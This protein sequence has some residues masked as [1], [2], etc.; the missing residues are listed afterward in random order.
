MFLYFVPQNFVTDTLKKPTLTAITRDDLTAIGLEYLDRVEARHVSVGPGGD[1][2]WLVYRTIHA[3]PIYEPP[4]Q[5]WRLRTGKAGLYIGR[6]NGLT[7]GPS[8]L[9]RADILPGHAV[10]LGD[11]RQ[12]IIPAARQHDEEGA[13]YCALPCSIGMNDQGE[14]NEFNVLHKYQKLWSYVGEYFVLLMNAIEEQGKC[15]FN[16]PNFIPLC[17]EAIST[18]YCVGPIEISWLGLLTTQNRKFIADAV[19]DMPTFKDILQK[20]RQ[21]QDTGST[22]SGPDV[23]TQAP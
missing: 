10:Q 16:F 4:K 12:W 7:P 20:K 17:I 8:D 13:G 11:D 22:S 15:K 6:I 14:W 19:M 18:N 5:Q 23:S 9:A 3:P 21:A 1:P 2:G